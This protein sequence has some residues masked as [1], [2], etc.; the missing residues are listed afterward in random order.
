L[1]LP[2]HHQTTW[3]GLLDY[4]VEAE[5][6]VRYPIP[7]PLLIVDTTRPVAGVLDEIMTWIAEQ[8]QGLL[9]V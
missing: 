6:R 1:S 7:T 3:T 5:P 9:L 4:L 2:A 8:T